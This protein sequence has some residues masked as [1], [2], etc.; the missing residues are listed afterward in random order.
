M[1]EK[2]SIFDEVFKWSKLQVVK[3]KFWT[4]TQISIEPNE[5]AETYKTKFDQISHRYQLLDE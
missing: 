5:K 4:Y 2:M 3:E 1:S